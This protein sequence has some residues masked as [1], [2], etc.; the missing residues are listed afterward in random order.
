M[1]SSETWAPPA[2]AN[3]VFRA[4]ERRRSLSLGWSAEEAWAPGW[5]AIDA[6]QPDF[7]LTEL[8]LT[9]P[10]LAAV[11][12]EVIALFSGEL[13]YECAGGVIWWSPP[14]RADFFLFEWGQERGNASWHARLRL[15]RHHR[16]RLFVDLEHGGGAS[17]Q[18]SYRETI[19]ARD[20]DAPR[21]PLEVRQAICEMGG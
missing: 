10:D 20:F 8:A 7:R 3:H 14:G 13:T 1:T 16:G 17:R 12:A 15:L 4:S 18:T 11:L 2:R 6:A 19:M 5:D 21:L 9:D